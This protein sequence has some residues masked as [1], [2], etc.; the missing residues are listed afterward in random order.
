[1]VT[2]WG[3]H[4]FVSLQFKT[5]CN[6]TIY[7]LKVLYGSELITKESYED[8]M[9]DVEKIYGILTASIKTAKSNL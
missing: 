9:M 2:L 7:W 1:M 5:E 4:F 6:E 8:I 3:R